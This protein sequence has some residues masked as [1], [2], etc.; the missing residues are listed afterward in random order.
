MKW[1]GD[2]FELS[3]KHGVLVHLYCV[4]CA[5]DGAVVVVGGFL[6]AGWR[7]IQWTAEEERMGWDALHKTLY[8]RTQHSGKVS[9]CLRGSCCCCCCCHC[10]L[11]GVSDP[12]VCV[13][14]AVVLGWTIA[15]YY[16]PVCVDRSPCDGCSSSLG[17][18]PGS[19]VE[20]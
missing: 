6:Y 9:C 3:T 19:R 7:C 1:S 12:L 15:G 10:W 18:A 20:R 17:I 4:Q 5:S 8:T 2:I 11:R 13:N 14:S 16:H